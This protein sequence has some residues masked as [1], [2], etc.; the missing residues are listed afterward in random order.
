MPIVTPLVAFLCSVWAWSI[1]SG[2]DP[3]VRYVVPRSPASGVLR[4]GDLIEDVRGA[5]PPPFA[6]SLALLMP[7]V[8]QV[9][10]FYPGDKIRLDI[11]RGGRPMVVA[12]TLGQRAFG[13]PKEPAGTYLVLM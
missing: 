4:K 13:G 7:V 5:P 11:R 3:L 10:L 6:K 9:A 2:A 1:Y 8:D 12:V